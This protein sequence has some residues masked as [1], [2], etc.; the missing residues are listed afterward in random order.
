MTLVR[1]VTFS[2]YQKVKYKMS[3]MIGRATGQEEPLVTVNRPGSVPSAATIAC[4]TA[5][6]AAG[7]FVGSFFAC[8]SVSHSDRGVLISLSGPFELTKSTAQ[9]ATQ[10]AKDSASGKA[11]TAGRS[12][13]NKGTIATAREILKTR[14]RW[15]L[16]TGL[17]YHICKSSEFLQNSAT[18]YADRS[19][20]SSRY[21]WKCHFLPNLRKYEAITCQVSGQVLANV[22][23]R[24]RCGRWSLWCCLMDHRKRIFTSI[25]RSIARIKLMPR[26]RHIRSTQPKPTSRRIVS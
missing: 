17:H 5:A 23:E 20:I 13:Q 10:M 19:L 25:S 1:T 11:G 21:D 26:S 18:S 24:R 3:S 8:K 12:Y 4:F 15:G 6:G 7:G 2:T 14:G 9:M 22:S 16:Y